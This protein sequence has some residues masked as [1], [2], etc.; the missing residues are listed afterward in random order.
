[1]HALQNI[2]IAFAAGLFAGGL[3]ILIATQIRNSNPNGTTS[4]T[5]CHARQ[6]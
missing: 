5:T 2:A 6:R 1:M 4:E 3:A